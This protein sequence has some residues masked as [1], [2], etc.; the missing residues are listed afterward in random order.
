[1]WVKRLYGAAAGAGAL[2]V[3]LAPALA[4]E[5]IG[6]PKPWQMGFQPA[7]SPV[8]Q[9]L[10]NFHDFLLVV[11]TLISVFVILLMGYVLIRFRASRNPVPTKTVH[12]TLLEVIWTIVPII[13]L[14]II[15][16]PSFRL[17]YFMDRAVEAEMT[18]KVVGHQWWWTYEYPDNGNFVIDAFMVEDEDLQ[19][20]QLRLLET[21]ERIVVPVDTTI[22]LLITADDVIHAWAV[23]AL[24]VKLDA[25]PGRV[26]ETW[27]LVQRE[28][29]YYGQCSELCGINHGFMPI[30]VEAVSKERFVEWVAEAQQ[31]FGSRD[32]PADDRRIAARTTE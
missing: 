25:V 15:V 7:A 29:L 32:M 11:T 21:D 17:L 12:N 31:E 26:N 28:G 22:R 8:M 24:G 19:L 5:V 30:V 3:G 2:L 1:M 4:Q 16:V 20:G 27:M 23:P 14:V 10:D 9:R 18:L 13:V 6:A